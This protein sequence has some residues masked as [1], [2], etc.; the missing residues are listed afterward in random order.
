MLNINNNKWTV[1]YG[2][3]V[4]AVSAQVGWLGLKIHRGTES[5]FIR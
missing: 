3:S 5:V 1:V 2:S 4:Q